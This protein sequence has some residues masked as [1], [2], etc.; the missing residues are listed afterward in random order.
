MRGL[1]KSH[2]EDMTRN[3]HLTGPP[4]LP[5]PLFDPWTLN[6][7]VDRGAGLDNQNFER[8]LRFAFI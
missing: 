6:W 8:Y 2:F 7:L 5:L 4:S 1:D 3:H